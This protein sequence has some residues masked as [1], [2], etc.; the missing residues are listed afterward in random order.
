MSVSPDFL[1]EHWGYNVWATNKLLN[2]AGQLSQ[3]EL[4]RDFKT[5]DGSVLETLADLFWSETIWLKRFQHALPSSRPVKGANGLDYL[6]QHWPAL[7]EQWRQYLARVKDP[8]EKLTYRDFKGQ[9]WTHSLWMLLCHVVNHSTHHRGQ[10]SGFLRAMGYP[11]PS[12]DLVACHRQL[13][14]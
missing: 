10:V 11:P 5:A 4:T 13:S 2:A 12:L 7:H 1:Q 8:S 6:G 3:E 9:E 14:S